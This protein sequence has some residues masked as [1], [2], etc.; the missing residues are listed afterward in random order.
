M[1]V[2]TAI[3]A[4]DVQANGVPSSNG[5]G[6]PVDLTRPALS[7]GGYWG[8]SPVRDTIQSLRLDDAE[9]EFGSELYEWIDKDPIAGG[10]LDVLKNFTLSGPIQLMANKRPSAGQIVEDPAL[11]EVFDTSARIADYCQWVTEKLD[12]PVEETLTEFCEQAWKHGNQLADDVWRVVPRGDYEGELPGSTGR[13]LMAVEGIDHK[14]RGSYSYVVD[15][16]RKTLKAVYGKAPGTSEPALYPLEKFS[17]AFWGARQGDPEKRAGQ[18]VYRRAVH[19]W[20]RRVQAWPEYVKYLQRFGTPAP[21]GKLWTDNGKIDIYGK[22]D[23]LGG[24]SMAELFLVDIMDWRAGRGFVMDSQSDIGLKEPTGDGKVFRDYLDIT[25]IETVLAILYQVGSTQESQFDSRAKSETS[26]DVLGNILRYM[27][28]WVCRFWEWQFLY[29]IVQFN[30]GKRYADL[31]T[32]IASLGDTDAADTAALLTALSRVGY[33]LTASQLPPLDA[34]AGVPVRQPGEE[35]IPV[36]GTVQAP[37]GD[38]T[39][40][41]GG[42]G[43]KDEG[44]AAA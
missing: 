29:R 7:G 18:S 30:W 4:P 6:K 33:R 42:T 21:Y 28:R 13:T 32:P 3:P 44:K 15:A 39:D 20:N 31:Y 43:G 8:V 23:E 41:T 10:S 9:R 24:K 14:P 12:R 19:P 35:T 27:K 5:D 40:G 22:R 26:M 34:M 25:R 37:G 36:A 2:T 1:P 17:I 11:Q 16:T 38:G